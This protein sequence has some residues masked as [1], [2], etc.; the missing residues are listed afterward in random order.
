MELRRVATYQQLVK[1][2]WQP[3]TDAERDSGA[4][5]VLCNNV[6]RYDVSVSINIS[7][8]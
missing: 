1:V 4:L 3:C 5:R 2:I 8:D 7:G 6:S